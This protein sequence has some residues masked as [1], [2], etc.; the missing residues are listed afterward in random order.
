[1][2]GGG[3]GTSPG[4]GGDECLCTATFAVP[5]LA[6]DAVSPL[7]GFAGPIFSGAVAGSAFTDLDAA[8]AG[9]VAAGS[10]FADLATTVDGSGFEGAG[11]AF[12][13]GTAVLA[14]GC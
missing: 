1:M 2:S 14:G 11:L 5:L 10:A 7:I 9:A 8:A 13:T 12:T 3:G 4:R 6:F